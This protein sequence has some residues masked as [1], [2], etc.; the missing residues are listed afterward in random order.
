MVIEQPQPWDA[1]LARA[2]EQ[3][4]TVTQVETRHD[5]RFDR[6]YFRASS[7]TGHGFYTVQVT[8]NAGG[9]FSTC[10]CPSGQH[11]KACKHQ[12][13]CLEALGLLGQ[14]EPVR[15]KIDSKAALARLQGDMEDAYPFG[16]RAA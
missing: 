13:K 16:G 10:S 8:C 3:G 1:A 12:A 9:V 6:T 2:R 14:F 7:S 5:A 11:D 4:I 15:T